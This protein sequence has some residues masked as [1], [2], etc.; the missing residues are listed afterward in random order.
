MCAAALRFVGIG[1]V[2]FVAD[3]LSDDSSPA[4]IIASR[5]DVPYEPLGDSSW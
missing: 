3:D 4:A 2:A 1:K 5:G